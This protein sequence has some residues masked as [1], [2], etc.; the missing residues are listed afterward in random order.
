MPSQDAYLNDFATRSFRDMADMDYI[1]ARSAYRLELYPQ[2]MWSGLQ[3][4]E[5]YSRESCFSIASPSRRNGWAITSVPLW[6][7]PARRC[8]FRSCSHRPA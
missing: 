3:A 1:A 6:L 7:W 5:K 8:P 4:I 2:F